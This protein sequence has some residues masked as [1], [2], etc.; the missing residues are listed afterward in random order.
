MQEI[1]IKA[2]Q[3]ILCLSIIITLHELGHFVAARAFKAKVDKFYLFFDPWFSIFKKKIGDT[4]YGIGWLPLGGYVKIAGMIDESMDKEQLKND[5]QPWEFRSKPAWQKLIIMAAGVIVNII[6]AVVIYACMAYSYGE[7]YLPSKNLIYGIEVNENGKA[8]GFQNGDKIIS[9]NGKSVTTFKSIVKDI[10]L[11]GGEVK[12]LRNGK[13]EVIHIS[14]K[15]LKNIIED[16]N[17]LSPAIP[18]SIANIIK[19]SPAQEIGLQKG[20]KI[21]SIDGKHLYY[22][23][24]VHQ[25]LQQ[26]KKENI[27][28]TIDRSGDTLY[29]DVI[30]KDNKIGIFP[31]HFAQILNFETTEH[32]ILGSIPAGINK[33]YT[34]LTNYIK[35]FKLVF[36]TEIQ[37]YKSLGGFIAIGKQ[38]S[39]AWDWYSFWNF[40]AFFSLALAFINILP[41]PALDG[42]HII[43]TLYEIITGRKPKQKVLEYAQVVG[44]FI[45]LALMIFVNANDV[46]KLF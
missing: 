4:V 46:I 2:S 21:V 41:I 22:F 11:D 26:H 18:Y 42:G 39:P 10:I 12:V 13:E 44:F 35:Q 32:S 17:F 14:D 24:E 27:N 20:D 45:L 23:G 1:I 8:M 38:F 34:T 36:N 40:T 19:N 6:T 16:P 29:F 30:K 25:Y 31:K 33:A 28:L 7:E 9:I 3:F 15:D 5:P 37:G 43:F